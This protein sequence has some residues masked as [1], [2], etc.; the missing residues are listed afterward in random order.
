MNLQLCGIS[1]NTGI[2]N[3][4]GETKYLFTIYILVVPISSTPKQNVHYSQ[5]Q[6]YQHMALKV[7]SHSGTK[8]KGK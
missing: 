2:I 6:Y 7:Q 5:T 3:N 4:T 8:N 1:N